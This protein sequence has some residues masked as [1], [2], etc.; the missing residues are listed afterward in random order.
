MN[1]LILSFADLLTKID[2]NKVKDEIIK[3]LIKVIERL[4]ER[5]QNEDT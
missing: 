2:S 5:K 1:D 3:E 4:E